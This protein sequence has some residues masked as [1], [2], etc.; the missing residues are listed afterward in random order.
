[1]LSFPGLDMLNGT[2]KVKVT[3]LASQSVNHGTFPL[4]FTGTMG[5]LSNSVTVTLTVK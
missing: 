3:L 1:M 2:A 4:K 5:I